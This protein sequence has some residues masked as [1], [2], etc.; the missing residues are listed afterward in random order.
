M[1][2]GHGAWKASE[3][4]SDLDQLLSIVKHDPNVNASRWLVSATLSSG[5]CT[6]CPTPPIRGARGETLR[7]G[8]D[9]SSLWCLKTTTMFFEI[10]K[11]LVMYWLISS[12]EHAGA[13][14]FEN[15]ARETVAPGVMHR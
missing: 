2:V 14:I 13:I 9:G 6:L 8:P 7:R 12:G 10:S 1:P 4:L 5:L 15:G 11:A 3:P